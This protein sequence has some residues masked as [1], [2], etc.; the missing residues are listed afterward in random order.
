LSF[1]SWLGKV[2]AEGILEV[3]GA[4]RSYRESFAGTFESPE[5]V[6]EFY[7]RRHASTSD[8]TELTTQGDREPIR[9]PLGEGG[10]NK[11]GSVETNLWTWDV[12]LFTA[13]GIREEHRGLF[14]A[15]L[16]ETACRLG[17]GG[18]MGA[19]ELPV[20]QPTLAAVAQ[21]K[22]SAEMEA[23]F[24]E[25]RLDPDNGK[26]YSWKEFRARFEKEYSSKDME[27]YW[28]DA[29]RLLVSPEV[30]AATERRVDPNDGR[31][32]TFDE[33]KLEYKGNYS[34][35]DIRKYWEDACRPIRSRV[36]PSA[37]DGPV[38]AGTRTLREA[39]SE[40]VKAT[41]M[42]K[43]GGRQA[44]GD[45]GSEDGSSGSDLEFKPHPRADALGILGGLEKVRTSS[46]A[47][48]GKVSSSDLTK[49]PEIPFFMRS[50][51]ERT[52][53]DLVI[54]DCVE[55]RVDPDEQRPV[56]LLEYKATH[57]KQYTLEEIEEYWVIACKSVL[58]WKKG[59]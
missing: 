23:I 34:A 29:C 47:C 42:G 44:S 4:L 24:L 11:R 37:S 49:L 28:R 46:G 40:P 59:R 19:G 25:R 6:I 15:W 32:W 21:E 16:E 8:T 20:S 27:D 58:D 22:C 5:Q 33:F 18:G 55:M 7:A 50:Y 48:S 9:P 41:T 12:E 57:M 52:G 31:V 14:T 54:D 10:T 38:F 39:D 45:C 26:V 13:V 56:A 17:V 43:D 35:E 36:P 3:E 2:D 53:I 30:F 51:K 1:S